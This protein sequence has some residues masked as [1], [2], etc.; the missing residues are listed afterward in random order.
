MTDDDE[1][2][3]IGEGPPLSGAP[4]DEWE[5]IG[6]GPSIEDS[7]SGFFSLDTL[8]NLG[9]SFTKGAVGLG[10]SIADYN[11]L[12]YQGLQRIGSAGSRLADYLRGVEHETTPWE[13][14]LQERSLTARVEPLRKEY[15]GDPEPRNTLERYVGKATEM[16]PAALSLNPAA[17]ISAAGAGLGGEA[18]TD[19]GAPEWLGALLGG[20]APAGAGGLIKT[21]TRPFTKGGQ[22]ALAGKDLLAQAGKEGRANLEKALASSAGADDFGPLTYAEMAEAPSAAAFQ[23]AMRKVPGEGSN[24]LEAALATRQEAREGALKAL[25]PDALEKVPS[26]IRG[27]VIQPEA[28]ELTKLAWEKAGN[29][30]KALDASAKI[31][32][33]KERG[34]IAAL[35]DDLFGNSALG[36]EA[37]T[38]KV[39]KAFTEAGDAMSFP[40]LRTLQSEAGEVI[41]QIKKTKTKSKDLVLLRAMRD[42]I[43]E[44]MEGASKSGAMD[45][46]QVLAYRRAK[47][48]YKATGAQFGTK[49]IGD[50]TRQGQFAQGFKLAEEAV[51]K[52]ILKD[53]RSAKEFVTAFGKNKV[54]M[55]QA[56]GALVD[57]MA[58]KPFESWPRFFDKKKEVFEQIFSKDSS[59]VKQV[60]DSI[61]KEKRVGE[62]AAKA[63]KGQSGTAQF[64]T[65]AQK[66]ITGGPRMILKVLGTGLGRTGAAVGGYATGHV[67]GA[68]GGYAAASAARWA[69]TNIENLIVR[70]MADPDLLKVLVA[71]ASDQS[72]RTAVDKLLPVIAAS[73]MKGAGETFQSPVERSKQEAPQKLPQKN[74]PSLDSTTSRRSLI[75]RALDEA[76]KK[77]LEGEARKAKERISMDTPKDFNRL[78]KAVIHQESGGKATAV[79]SKGARG[80]MQIMPETAKEIAQELGVK[81]YDLNDPATNQ[82]FGEH[83]LKKMLKLF[84]DKELALAA[85]NLGPGALKKLMKESGLSSW[86]DL[87]KYLERK[88]KYLETVNYVPSV[89]KKEKFLRT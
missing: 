18:A 54:L 51:P 6:E 38:Q 12:D 57:E 85:Y 50:I 59:K 37:D 45:P 29:P 10:T 19:M 75:E 55:T 78:V 20:I 36:M 7:P 69:E 9:K 28:A 34:A 84:G 89:L 88:K 13:Q 15:V 3:L 42:R 52:R 60:L 35:K 25:A 47:E 23:T 86:G 49:T 8:K 64:T 80:L 1:W 46:A 65:V 81:N 33:T 43:D 22:Q 44:A 2:E 67:S 73:Q 24:A 27:N 31:P 48:G 83:Y 26:S 40:A 63:S 21:A 39:V 11:P 66:L 16:L 41:G 5:L 32:I 53:Q 87:S 76:E 82:K 17:L 58:V 30:Y 71:R 74:S 62:L 14:Q 70:G 4:D 61:A 56:R 68:V 79:S 72:L 77:L